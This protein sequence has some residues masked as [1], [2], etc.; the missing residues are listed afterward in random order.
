MSRVEPEYFL[1]QSNHFGPMLQGHLKT[2][3]VYIKW[4]IFFIK[5]VGLIKLN[6]Y[7][8]KKMKVHWIFT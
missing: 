6:V 4:H 2:N 8:F 5:R 7:L 1:Q 3:A